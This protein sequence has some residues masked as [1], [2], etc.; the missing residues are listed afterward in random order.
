MDS[1]KTT[2]R[3]NKTDPFFQKRMRTGFF[4]S[5]GSGGFFRSGQAGSGKVQTKGG[6]GGGT[7]SASLESSLSSTRGGG[8][9][10]STETNSSMSEAFGADLSG[11]RI[12]HDSTA[13]TMNNELSSHAFT[14]G[15]DIYFN[16]G[17]YDDKSTE[18]K[19]LLAHELTH[20]LQQSGDVHRFESDEH[21][22]LGREGSFG[23]HG[24]T[25]MVRL[26]DDYMIEY[27]EMVAMAGDFFGSIAQ[28]RQLAANDGKGAGTREELEYVRVVKIHNQKNKK[29]NYSKGAVEAADK[30]YYELALGNRSHFLNPTVGDMGKTTDEKGS[31][32]GTRFRV[33][34]FR[35]IQETVPLNSVAA[36]R[37]NHMQALVEA[38]TA[39][40]SG[41]SIDSAL[42]AEAFSNHFLTDS[43][44]A[45]HV[46]TPRADATEYWNKKVPM[47][48]YNLK[49]Y[50]AE[51]MAKVL[52]VGVNF[53]YHQLKK[54]VTQRLD[55][56]GYIQFGDV[57]S[58]ALHD[59][60]NERGVMV[61][62]NGQ[63][64]RTFGDSH[65]DDKQNEARTYIPDAVRLS[66]QDV[67]MVW[68][69]GTK[70]E[71]P[72]P[73]IQS[74]FTDHQFEAE[75][76]LPQPLDESELPDKDKPLKWDFDGV[77]SLLGDSRFDDALAIFA[78]NKAKDFKEIADD[79][80]AIA[81]AVLINEIITPLVNDPVGTIRNIVNWVPNTGGGIFGHDEDD[82]AMEY[83]EE[84]KD[85]DALD[86][87][88]TE[89]RS[90]LI[91]PIVSGFFNYVSDDE[92]AAVMRLFETA[93]ADQRPVIY[94]QVEGHAWTGDFIHGFWVSDDD[95][96]DALS[97][98]NL[99]KLRRLINEG[100]Q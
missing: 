25:Q 92:E 35:M 65:L 44:A 43:F 53:A 48:N 56:K 16:S 29:D 13:A 11:V 76:L 59:Y 89:Q 68:E 21:L 70:Q 20:T 95:L 19:K 40:L 96:W 97:G 1:H 98:A 91:K 83:Y 39:G 36:Y 34:G 94:E 88:S 52:P 17:K 93:P 8:S 85:K 73:V 79:L 10:M 69:A 45:G 78:V 37:M 84:A 23:P 61:R 62:I 57:V 32:L 80:P 81:G 49:G 27:G 47:F 41:E 86:T 18:G 28:M 74:L 42:A 75:K 15:N 71:N 60:Y 82:N 14:H 24:E 38:Y 51:R 31:E 26:A 64:V 5:A 90:G 58:G 2:A 33:E 72:L 99:K 100:V 63:V 9:P 77:A 46:L 50:I 66:L 3:S 4:H 22:E 7:A 87:L 54:I 30:R 12:H 67:Q 6:D 55:A